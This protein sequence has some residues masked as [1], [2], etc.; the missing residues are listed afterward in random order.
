M[1]FVPVLLKE[2][3]IEKDLSEVLDFGSNYLQ[4]MLWLS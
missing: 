2:L 3:K 1:E 4:V